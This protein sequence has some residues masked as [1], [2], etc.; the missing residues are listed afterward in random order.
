LKGQSRPSVRSRYYDSSMLRHEHAQVNLENLKFCRHRCL[1]SRHFN[2]QAA[3]VKSLYRGKEFSKNLRFGRGRTANVLPPLLSWGHVKMK[4]NLKLTG[5]DHRASERRCSRVDWSPGGTGL[6]PVVFG[7]PAQNRTGACH[8]HADIRDQSSSHQKFGGTPN[9]DRP[10][11]CATVMPL[12]TSEKCLESKQGQESPC[13][14]KTL[15]FQHLTASVTK[16]N[17]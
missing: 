8:W 17:L 3:N 9:L 6:R 5:A 14:K 11:A 10:E 4:N 12:K 13:F 16:C 7:R 15:K 2:T 1:R